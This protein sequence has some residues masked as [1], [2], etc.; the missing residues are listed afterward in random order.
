[1]AMRH[2]VRLAQAISGLRRLLGRRRSP[3]VTDGGELA[4][5]LAAQTAYVAQ[6]SVIEY[7]RARTG[8][9]WDKLFL[10]PAFL[11]RLEVCR[12][13]AYA[14]VLAE[15]AELALIRLRR[16]GAADPET[17]LP[18]LVEAA[19]AALL[20]HPVP[21][22]RLSWT[23]AAEAIEGHLARALLAAPRPVHLLGLHSAGIIFDLLPIH[24]DL[25]QQD[26]EMFQNSVRFAMCRAFDAMTRGFDVPA[27]EASL[28]A[29]DPRQGTAAAR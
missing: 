26:R 10:E 20:R 7:C 2:D 21:S 14:V 25:R 1:M 18:G 8:P 17:Y 23:D 4:D 27:L 3:L 19:H 13:D 24:A 9:N 29:P 15:V 6:R 11:E 22:H 5:F 28:L 16:D 12:W